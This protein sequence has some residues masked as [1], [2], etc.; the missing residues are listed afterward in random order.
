MMFLSALLIDTGTDPD[1]PRPGRLWLRNRY[2]VHQRL[3]MAFPSAARIAADAD[4]LQPFVPGDFADGQVRVAR[5]DTAGFLFRI[6]TKPGGGV[7]IL[8]QSAIQ[9]DWTYAFHNAPL[10]AAP[11][12]VIP[13]DPRFARQE[14]LRF[15]LLANP[16]KRCTR[17]SCEPDGHL[18]DPKWVG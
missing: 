4:F 16:T 8:V 9:P 6:D 5:G 2:R 14:R 11:A 7:V 15:R 18:V 17:Q 13:F 1:R 10:L 3:C 12:Q